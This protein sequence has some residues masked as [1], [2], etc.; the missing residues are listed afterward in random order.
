[1][2]LNHHKNATNH[3]ENN[4]QQ[5]TTAMPPP[6][7]PAAT[8][9][10]GTDLIPSQNDMSKINGNLII[11]DEGIN[12]LHGDWLLV[13]RRKKTAN[14]PPINAHKNMNNRT[15]KFSVLSNLASQNK[16]NPSTHKLPPKPSPSDVS[17]GPSV[18]KR[19]RQDYTTNA[20]II[21]QSS[22]TQKVNPPLDFLTNQ[23]DP[24]ILGISLHTKDTNSH[25]THPYDSK[26]NHVTH[27][28]TPHTHELQI[29]HNPTHENNYDNA[30]ILSNSTQSNTKE[31]ASD[32]NFI[33]T[34][35]E[36]MLARDMNEDTEVNTS[37]NN[38]SHE[39]PS[40]PDEDMVI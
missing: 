4:H 23:L 6:S 11:I 38:E 12:E 39:S 34:D 37:V 14:T 32:T 19:R 22:S 29:S 16:P 21:K 18:P 7:I 26:N 40:Q 10:N 27:I 24:T 1:M 9:S 36:T 8:N 5:P 30:I 15:N 35:E 13:T 2:N 25:V 28:L 33:Q 20:P 3:Q 31:S 17:R